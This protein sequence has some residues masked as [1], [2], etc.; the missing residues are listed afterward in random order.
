MMTVKFVVQ[1]NYEKAEYHFS[2][3]LPTSAYEDFLKV[4]NQKTQSRFGNEF[5]VSQF[6]CTLTIIE[7]EPTVCETANAVLE[8]ICAEMSNLESDDFSEV[9]GI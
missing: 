6:D 2:Y 5:Y 8:D 7:A 3:S 1:I 9:F 4:L